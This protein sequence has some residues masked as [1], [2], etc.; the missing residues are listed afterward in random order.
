MDP[1][2][3]AIRALV[4][5]LFLLGAIRLS[6]KRT[7]SEGTAFD[8]V[9][10]LIV[11]DLIDDVLFAEVPVANFVVAVSVLVMMEI[12]GAILVHKYDGF[13][14][15]LEGKPRIIMEGG[16]LNFNVIKREFLNEQE[17]S[18]L[19]RLD[20]VGKEKWQQLKIVTI[21]AEGQ[22]SVLK[23]TEMKDAKKKDG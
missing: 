2:R 6:G 7:V 20:G 14:W 13:V 1:T 17:V 4:S 18:A 22:L 9:L 15:L 10:S 3:V 19:L 11:G 16:R 12:T 5:F 23:R 8:L 21:E